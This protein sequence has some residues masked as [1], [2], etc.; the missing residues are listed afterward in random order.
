MIDGRIMADK[1]GVGPPQSK[2]LARNPVNPNYLCGH[3]IFENALIE[4]NE[5]PRVVSCIFQTLPWVHLDTVL[6][7]QIVKE[8]PLRQGQCQDAPK[9]VSTTGKNVSGSI[10]RS[11]SAARLTVET[12]A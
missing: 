6:K 4:N 3:S 8:S 10:G 1:S 12:R 5:T 7:F 11:P 9:S 2:T